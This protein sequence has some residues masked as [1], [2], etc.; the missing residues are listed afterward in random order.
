M[1][2]SVC[3]VR[4]A[5]KN[6]GCSVTRIQSA[7]QW[8]RNVS[9]I[10]LFT[11]NRIKMFFYYY[12]GL[13]L[14]TTQRWSIGWNELAYGFSFYVL[15]FKDRSQKYHYYIITC[16]NDLVCYFGVFILL[17]QIQVWHNN[18]YVTPCKL[19]NAFI[20]EK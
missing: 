18:Q 2:I 3:L 14:M 17:C 8:W 13:I 4:A 12:S 19:R 9:V 16:T 5:S 1:K 11:P 15:W 6:Q 10:G 7:E 20:N